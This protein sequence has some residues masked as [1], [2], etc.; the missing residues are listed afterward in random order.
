MA[1]SFRILSITD[2]VAVMEYL[3]RRQLL[4]DHCGV[5]LVTKFNQFHRRC[6]GC[7]SP[8]GEYSKAK[9]P[10]DLEKC[11]VQALQDWTGTN[12]G[13]GDGGRSDGGDPPADQG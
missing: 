2:A 10:N 7:V 3:H 9:A 12:D 5:R 6:D 8:H 4:C 13:S 1:T 11:I